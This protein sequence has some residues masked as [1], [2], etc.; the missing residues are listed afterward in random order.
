MGDADSAQ[1]KNGIKPFEVDQIV[2]N[3]TSLLSISTSKDK[4]KPAGSFEIRLAPTKNWVTAI[5]P[6]SWCIILMS[7]SAI[8]DKAKYGGGRVDEKSFKMLGR[9]ESVRGVIEV[10]QATG[11]R[12]TGY[13]VQGVDWGTIFD[14]TLYVDPLNRAGD[15]SSIGEAL[16]FGYEK[17]IKKGAS[18]DSAKYGPKAN[19]ESP[20]KKRQELQANA[21]TQEQLGPVKSTSNVIEKGFLASLFDKTGIPYADKTVSPAAVTSTKSVIVIDDEGIIKEVPVG[22]G[23]V[24]AP[25]DTVEENAIPLKTNEQLAEEAEAKKQTAAAEKKAAADA[26]TAQK[27]E[28]AKTGTLSVGEKLPSAG[29]AV[30]FL[31]SLWGQ[32]DAVTSAMQAETGLLGKS[33]QVFKI[34]AKASEYMQFKDGKGKVS[35][36]ISQ[37][38]TPIVGKLK[39]GGK[40]F[41]D[42]YTGVDRS[43]GLINFDTILGEHSMWQV[44]ND[45]CNAPIN[46]LIPEIRFDQ[47]G[48]AT[49]ALYQRV[50]PF[51]IKST[52]EI[53]ADDKEVGDRTTAP[54]LGP[55]SKDEADAKKTLQEAKRSLADFYFSEFKKVR[56]KTIDVQDVITCNF[57]TNWRD[58]YNFIEINV[59]RSLFQ[60]SFSSAIK[61]QSQFKDADS[62]GRDGLKSMIQS[63]SYIPVNSSGVQ[64]VLDVFVYKYALKEWYFNTHKMLNGNIQVIGQ[65]QYI[66]VGDNIR[67][68]AEAL[69]LAKNISAAQKASRRFT[70]LTAHVESISHTAQIDA[71][72]ARS[73]I[74]NINFT[75]GIITDIDGNLVALPG[76]AGAVD[77]DAAQ[78]TPI[79]EKNTGTFG[80]SGSKDPDRQKLRGK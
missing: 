15:G 56:T 32:T 77:Q 27:K 74:T 35:N 13:I 24:L 53:L 80:T 59:D 23:T 34:P 8:N 26:A 75:R 14:S 18:Y 25:T 54:F 12:K 63:F 5:T 69:G 46:E 73:F 3:T 33:Q 64:S 67:V 2:L 20:A 52:A 58:K 30:K 51:A 60:E 68:E 65:D 57:G 6:G 61:L 72:G 41:N 7:N 1:G 28:D 45:N 76:N 44:L 9:I 37:V 79:V 38:I 62:I 71:N 21:S 17:F 29:D 10:D 36:I 47:S 40:S 78:V 22:T 55:L 16:R 50:R 4:S 48:Q 19:E 39:N 66:Q 70:H 31:L 49:M 43:A 42:T 11:A